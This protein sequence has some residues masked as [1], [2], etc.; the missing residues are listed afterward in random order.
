MLFNI[1]QYLCHTMI[2]LQLFITHCILGS[3]VCSSNE[4]PKKNRGGRGSKKRVFEDYMSFY[5]VSSGLK[6]GELIQVHCVIIWPGTFCVQLH[7]LTKWSINTFF[8]GVTENQS[9]KI[10]RGICS[11]S[12]EYNIFQ[13][14]MIL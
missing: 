4:K 1:L 10:S 14:I 9:E 6:R 7:I 8:S 12:S 13:Q 11:F 3:D 2:T 5:D